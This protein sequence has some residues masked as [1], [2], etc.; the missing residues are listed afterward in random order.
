MKFDLDLSREEH[1]GLKELCTRYRITRKHLL[2]AFIADA[3]GSLRSGGS[4]ERMHAEAWMERRCFAHYQMPCV[5][6]YEDPEKLPTGEVERR[7]TWLELWAGAAYRE[8]ENKRAVWRAFT[9][10]VEPYR[11]EIRAL[12]KEPHP[13]LLPCLHQPDDDSDGCVARIY[14]HTPGSD[15][16][17]IFTAHCATIE[18]AAE[19]LRNW[20][21]GVVIV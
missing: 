16:G 4:D 1:A 9:E 5:A 2:E 17:E 3:T 21:N 14:D 19:A 11:A 13:H 20:F 8:R 6:L 18:Q 12:F 10:A 15:R 7:R